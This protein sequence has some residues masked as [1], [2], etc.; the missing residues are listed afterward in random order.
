MK[1]FA[2]I[3]LGLSTTASSFSFPGTQATREKLKIDL[4]KLSSD[5]QRGLTASPEQQ[6][7]IESLFEKLEKVNPTRKPL[8][9][10]KVN[11]DWS[12]EYTTSDSILGK[13]GF[14]R[15]GKIVQKID[16]TTLSA[17][18]SEVVSYFGVKVPRKVTAELDPQNDKFTNVKFRRFS[19]GPIGFDAPES[20]RGSLDITYLDDDLRLTRGDKG[21]IFVLT[22]MNEK[23]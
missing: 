17:E 8:K 21:N 1:V 6:A 22:R 20:F 9:T 5:T 12:L 15:V 19:L 7:Q 16:T 3:L 10:T 23:N 11:G 2:F 14:P 4:L 13:G 18:N